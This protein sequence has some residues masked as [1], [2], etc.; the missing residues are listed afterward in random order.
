MLIGRLLQGLAAAVVW[1][2][3]LALLVDTVGS[4]EIGQTMGYVS[5]SLTL[6][7]FLAPISGGAV[8]NKAG[9]YAVY[10]MSFGMIFLDIALRVILVEKKVAK[11]WSVNE[12]PQMID[13]P[14]PDRSYTHGSAVSDLESD[15]AHRPLNLRPILALLSSRRLWS[16]LWCSMVHSI[17]MSAWDATLPLH[18]AK[19]FNFNSLGAGLMFLPMSLPTMFAPVV[20]KYVDTHGTRIPATVGF[21]ACA[22]PVVLLLLV[23]HSG[24][25][26]IILMC[27][28]LAVLGFSL[29]VTLVPFLVEVTNIV[30]TMEKNHP[31]V[32]GTTGAFAQGYGLYNCAFA[33]GMLIGPLW[34]GFIVGKAGWGT[35]CWSLGILS[36]VSVVPAALWT[37]GWIFGKK[38][39]EAGGAAVHEMTVEDGLKEVER[40]MGKQA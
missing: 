3:G 6:A 38:S 11:Q 32:F 9:Y 5:I 19:L 28:L 17:L 13:I 23:N 14:T 24:I 1:T 27:A 37:G 12:E 36:A 39:D 31:G 25:G 7:T 40:V 8:F 15:S 26:Q 22:P 4:A 34:G 29:T 30:A 33:G 18:V 20:G 21:L 10:Y 35:M 16:A 2:V